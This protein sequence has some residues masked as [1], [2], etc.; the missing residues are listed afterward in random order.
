MDTVTDIKE[1]M[2]YVVGDYDQ[3]MRDSKAQK[4][5]EKEY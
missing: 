5:V 3:A 4:N 1:R 2:C